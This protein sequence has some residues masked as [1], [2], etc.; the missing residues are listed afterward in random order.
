M[1]DRTQSPVKF[2]S[3][4]ILFREP[5]TH[6]ASNGL[7]IYSFSDERFKTLKLEFVFPDAGSACDIKSGTNLLVSK[8]LQSGTKN[9]SSTEIAK[10]IA[11]AGAFI[12]ISPSFDYTILTLYCVKKHLEKLLPII[13]EILLQSVFPA[14]EVQRQQ[15]ITKNGLRIQLKKTNIVASRTLRASLFPNSPYGR[16]PSVD[17]LS[18]VSSSDIRDHYKKCYSYFEIIAS[19]SVSTEVINSI[20]KSFFECQFNRNFELDYCIP[21][22]EFKIESREVSIKHSIQSSIRAGKIIIDKADKDYHNLFVVN[23][24]LGGFFGSRLMKNLREDKGLTYGI[25]SSII[26]LR[27]SCYLVIGCD[28]KAD[29]KELAVEEIKKEIEKLYNQDVDPLELKV[30]RNQLLGS[31]QNDLSSLNSLS[32]KFKSIN[33]QGL[34]YEYYD[35]LIDTIKNISANKVGEIANKYLSSDSFSFVSTT[36]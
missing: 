13:K 11:D 3:T 33:Y 23:H 22:N 10:V 27:H 34:S 4:D 26:D 25:H 8:C 32:G 5:E 20:N 15:E 1:L 31:I 30:L 9:Y 17:D 28:V 14:N 16:S 6:I 24:L 18:S 35:Q 19:G 36:H 12:D 2:N 7:R 21:N 29:Q